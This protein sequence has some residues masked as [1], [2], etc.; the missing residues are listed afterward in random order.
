MFNLHTLQSQKVVN[1][2]TESRQR[3]WELILRTLHPKYYFF[4]LHYL[5]SFLTYSHKL[6]VIRFSRDCIFICSHSLSL[7]LSS[8]CIFIKFCFLQLGTVNWLMFKTPLLHCKK[9]SVLQVNHCPCH[10]KTWRKCYWIVRRDI[11]FYKTH[12]SIIK[13]TK[14]HKTPS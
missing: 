1:V 2:E 13:L 12:S 6:C 9:L 5:T 11:S 7:F 8:A 10:C 3:W 4:Q 14:L